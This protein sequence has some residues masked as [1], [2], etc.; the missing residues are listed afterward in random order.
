MYHVLAVVTS[1]K[2]KET[3]FSL[4][5]LYKLDTGAE[6]LL[7]TKMLLTKL[8]MWLQKGGRGY[9]GPKAFLCKTNFKIF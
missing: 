2:K 1:Q 7:I 4:N 3:P 8:A 5:L 6:S 9:L